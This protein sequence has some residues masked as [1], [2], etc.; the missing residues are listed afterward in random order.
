[1]ILL[2]MVGDQQ[3]DFYYEGNSDPALMV[4]LWG[5]AIS[6]GYSQEFIP[7]FKW[8][9]DDDHIPFIKAGIPSVD[10]I[11]FDYPYWHTTQDTCDKLSAD[12]LGRVGR[13]LQ[14]WL[15]TDLPARQG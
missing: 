9:M 2:D 12:S 5:T 3:Q 6:L 8:S 10:I 15:N 4:Q 1:M 7:E 13:V 14:T 11:D